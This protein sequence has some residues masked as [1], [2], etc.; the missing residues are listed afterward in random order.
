MPSRPFEKFINFFF[1][2]YLQREGMSKYNK[3]Y[4][5]DYNLMNQ[6][7]TMVMTSV[8]GHLLNNDFSGQY[9]HW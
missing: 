7:V 4:E 8:S 3:I 1:V 6:N 5:F 9:K 2:C